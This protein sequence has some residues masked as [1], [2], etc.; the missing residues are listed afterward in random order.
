MVLAS[1]DLFGPSIVSTAELEKEVFD[2]VNARRIEVGLPPLVWDDRIA[3]VARGHGQDMAT[4]AMPF[5][6]E[7]FDDRIARIGASI[8]WQAA[9]EV[10]ARTGSA[11]E[12]VE[13]WL[14]GAGHKSQIEGDY[15]LTGVGV[16]EN[17]KGAGYYFDQIFI[18]MR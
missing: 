7:G 2:R 16:A 11:K 15:D 5:G 3:G 13:A 17:K 1:C 12:A 10:V 14:A 4:G 18:R 6:H 9:G 8:P